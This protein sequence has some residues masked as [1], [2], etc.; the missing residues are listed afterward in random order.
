MATAALARKEVTPIPKA[1]KAPKTEKP[2]RAPKAER[3]VDGAKLVKAVKAEVAELTAAERRE[4]ATLEKTIAKG[5]PV[6]WDTARALA[7]IREKRLYRGDFATFED[8]CQEKWQFTA[9]RA[10]QLIGAAG[11]VAALEAASVEVMPQ[12]E[13]Q[14]RPL[15]K[16]PE[17]EKGKVWAKAVEAADGGQP[18]REQVA[19]AAAEVIPPAPA[20]RA[21]T[22]APS[23]PGDARDVPATVSG[24]KFLAEFR[25]QLA[26]ADQASVLV[27]LPWPMLFQ[28]ACEAY[29][30][31]DEPDGNLAKRMTEGQWSR[32][33]N[34]E[35]TVGGYFEPGQ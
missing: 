18:T 2:P 31:D 21:E 26:P 32:A 5:V 7:A 8:Y 23:V 22:R 6:V 11:Q 14:V 27:Q 4:L 29:S 35:I 10:R 25:T 34:R 1:G 24:A 13:S 12:S 33:I 15:V 9:G 30:T 3:K 28:A 19:A 17:A 16:V 20:V